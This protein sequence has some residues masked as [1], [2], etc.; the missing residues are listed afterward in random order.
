MRLSFVILG[1]VIFFS[2]FLAPLFHKGVYKGHD[3]EVNIARFA[4]YYKAFQDGQ[5]PPR[6]A[7]DFNY[8]YGSPALI[9]FYPLPGYIASLIHDLGI[10]FENSYKILMG[11]AFI[12]APISWYLWSRMLVRNEIAIISSIIYGLVPYR[13]LNLYVRGDI[14]E[15]LSFVFI[16]IIF[17]FIEKTLRYSN[18]QTI[19]LGGIFYG[20]LILSHN[21]L[22]LIFSPVL[23]AYSLYRKT[24]K[25]SLLQIMPI[26]IIGLLISSFFFLPAIFESRYINISLFI[27]TFRN[28]FP[29]V[30][31][32]IYSS[33]GFGS[34]VN[35]PG[36]LSPQIGPLYILF[37][38]ASL[39]ILLTKKKH[40]ADIN[41]WL[42]VF[43]IAVFLATSASIFL[44]GNL[45]LIKL[46]QFPWRFVSLAS[47]ASA[48][49][50]MYVLSVIDNKKVIIGVFVLA[51]FLAMPFVKV[52]GYEERKDQ[53]YYMYKGTTSFHGETTTIW[54]AGDFY[55]LPKNEFEIIGGEGEVLKS[56]KKSNL[57]KLVINAKTNLTI[58][59]NTVYFP[60]W[61]VEVDNKKVPIEFQDPNYRGLITFNVQK[62]KHDVAISFGESPIRLF[63]DY[64]SIL[65]VFLVTLVLFLRKKINK[66]VN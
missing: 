8:S 29:L 32:L 17:L 63:S 24:S 39:F 33:W 57:H 52:N 43:A 58:L 56:G 37:V 44:W 47:F 42:I 5:V 45:P 48:T 49:L 36:G 62:G 66:I 22:S 27:E 13:F 25:V 7:G 9:F 28:N 18:I 31:K 10:S 35:K 3:S 20:L 15:L 4:A 2:L 64:V 21:V 30:S 40:R 26:F 16:P 61:R 38:F 34:D 41:F 11:L 55:T 23:L 65:G 60:G 46:F 1:L 59:D 12:L 53:Y 14:G 50:A 54:T 6:W 51:V 19:I